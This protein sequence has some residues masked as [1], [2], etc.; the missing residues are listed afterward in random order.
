MIERRGL[1]VSEGN[2][3]NRKQVKKGQGL[4]SLFFPQF[5]SS[6]SPN[7]PLVGEYD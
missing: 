3:R 1:I 7:Y 5:I 4:L 6:I 2:F